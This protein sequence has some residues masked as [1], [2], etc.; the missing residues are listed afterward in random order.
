MARDVL[1]SFFAVAVVGVVGIAMAVN[2]PPYDMYGYLADA[3]DNPPVN[4]MKVCDPGRSGE[5]NASYVVLGISYPRTFQAV[6]E[7]WRIGRDCRG[8]QQVAKTDLWLFDE[9]TT[10]NQLGTIR[11]VKRKEKK[12]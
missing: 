9:L 11:R 3:T 5:S 2:N 4:Y 10:S 1:K 12:R 6:A 7:E 8:G